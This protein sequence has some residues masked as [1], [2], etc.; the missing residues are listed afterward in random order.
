MREL[1]QYSLPVDVRF[2]TFARGRLLNLFQAHES[3]VHSPFS[4]HVGD[5]GIVGDSKSPRLQRTPFV[6]NLET[7]PELKM[8][9]LPQ[10]ETLFRVAFVSCRQSIQGAAKLLDRGSVQF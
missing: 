6:E 4:I 2:R 5:S 10:V 8:N 1:L 9:V 3:R 7:L